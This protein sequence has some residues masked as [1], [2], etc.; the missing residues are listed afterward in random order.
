MLYLVNIEFLILL[1]NT[2]K[3]SAMYSISKKYVGERYKI[4]RSEML[5]KQID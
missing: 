3:K 1:I 2:L 5:K 4:F